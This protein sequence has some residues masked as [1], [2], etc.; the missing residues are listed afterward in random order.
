MVLML[1]VR[2]HGTEIVISILDI[3]TV[4]CLS[5]IY[6]MSKGS[7]LQRFGIQRR[8]PEIIRERA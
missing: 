3:L 7:W 6:M 5:D 2:G 8:D 1:V 4:R